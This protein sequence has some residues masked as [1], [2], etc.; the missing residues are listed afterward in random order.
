MPPRKTKPKVDPATP[1][2]DISI[3]DLKDLS[4][5]QRYL[6]LA[7]PRMEKKF[8]ESARARQE[9]EDLSQPLLMVPDLAH[10]WALQAQG[11]RGGRSVV[12]AAEPGASKSSLALYLCNLARRQG[13]LADYLDIERA[14]NEDHLSY[15]LDDPE[16]FTQHIQ[17]PGTIEEAAEMMRETNKIYGLV[18]PERKMPKVEVLDAIGGAASKRELDS[19]R[20]LGDMKVGGVAGFM[21]TAAR[22]LNH[23]FTKVGT[24]GIYIN[25]AKEKIFTGY[26]AAVPRAAE[27]KVSFPGGKGVIYACSYLEYLKK[28]SAI[29][30]SEKARM[31]FTVTSTFWRNRGRINGRSYSYDVVFGETLRFFPHTMDFLV[32]SATLGL[33]AKNRKY[34]CPDIGVTEEHKLNDEEMYALIH[35][36]P[37]IKRRFQEALGIL[38]AEAV[39]DDDVEETREVTRK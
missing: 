12:L 5:S 3:E 27:D 15:Y 7:A 8:G 33:R 16:E 38:D 36:D 32:N 26:E 10:Q 29:K 9:L 2:D 4:P 35:D 25:H 22:V 39:P 6:R 23:E 18:D 31:G 19:D 34:W 21:T 1:T 11:Y 13:G 37:A 14:L 17:Q 28:G 24:I 30:D 20:E